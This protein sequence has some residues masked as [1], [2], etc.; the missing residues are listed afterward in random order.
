MCACA[1]VSLY[2]TVYAVGV[3]VY[4][5]CVFLCIQCVVLG[6]IVWIQFVSVCITIHIAVSLNLTLGLIITGVLLHS[7]CLPL[8]SI[9]E[10]CVQ[11][12]LTSC[13]VLFSFRNWSWLLR[14]LES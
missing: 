6:I 1:C 13:C 5:V 12:I 7:K 4:T 10:L 9:L 2:I 8:F 14:V 3:Y 11:I